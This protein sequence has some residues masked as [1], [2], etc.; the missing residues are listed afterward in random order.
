MNIKITNIVPALSAVKYTLS[1]R[2][3]GAKSTLM[4]E[5]ENDIRD[6]VP[7]NSGYLYESEEITDDSIEYTASYASYLYNS[8]RSFNQSFH[9]K[10]DNHW[11]EKAKAEKNASWIR[12]FKSEVGGK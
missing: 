10:A 1:T 11:I 12:K 2:I 9:K 6:F 8:N 7:Y 3:S 5:I 4:E